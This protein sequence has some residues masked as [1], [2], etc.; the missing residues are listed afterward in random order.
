MEKESPDPNSDEELNAIKTLEDVATA[1]R[2]HDN[3]VG[4]NCEEN[5]EYERV[6]Q[7]KE[8][9]VV[10]F[11]QVSTILFEKETQ[12]VSGNP[13][14]EMETVFGFKDLIKESLI[15]KR[16]GQNRKVLI[17]LLK[18]LAEIKAEVSADNKRINELPA[19]GH[20][21]AA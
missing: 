2:V 21:A 5:R 16:V 19:S 18:T 15:E 20:P 1:F 13:T 12:P 17:P 8:Q 9:A 4:V 7:L 10:I 3:A 6:R 14:K 11:R